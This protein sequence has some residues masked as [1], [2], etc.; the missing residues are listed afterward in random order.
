MD[1]R[2]AQHDGFAGAEL[3]GNTEAAAKYGAAWG[4]Y[5][6]GGAGKMEKMGGHT[7]TKLTPAQL[8]SWRKAVEPLTATW[9]ASA[10]KAGVKG[11]QVLDEYK[12][13]LKA[14]NASY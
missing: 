11:L 7:I 9:A 1:G 12:A 6:D 5:E 14:R 4:D 3:E 8:A 13:E 10:D 2:C